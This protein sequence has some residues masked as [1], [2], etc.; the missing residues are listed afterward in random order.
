MLA[1][2]LYTTEKVLSE[3]QLQPL[4]PQPR[5]RH[6]RRIEAGRD[7][8]G[9]MCTLLIS[10]NNTRLL[11]LDF[12]RGVHEVTK[13][14]PRLGA[15][16]APTD[17]TGQQSVEAA[18][19]Q[20][21]LQVAVDFHRYSR[22]QSI[23]VKEVDPIRDAVLDDHPL[24]VPPHQFGRRPC[25]LIGQ[26]DR[27]LLVTQVGDDHLT[28][29]TVVIGQRDPPIENP[30]SRVLARDPLQLDLSPCRLRHLV[31]LP[32]QP[33]GAP[34]QRDELNT[35]PVELVELGVGR[36]L[37]IENQF[38][39]VPPGTLLP[40][41]N[42]AE[43]LI[44]LLI[45][46][47]FAVGVAK[48]ARL[49]VL[50]QERQNALLSPT[51]LGHVMLLNQS[52]L[53]MEGD[54]VKIQV[55]GTTTRQT[56]P[57]HGVE[58]PA[59]QLGIAG[60]VDPATVLGQERPL[61][62]DVQ[63]SKERQPLV[64]DY[65]H[66]MAVTRRP[67]ELQCQQRAESGARWDHLRSREPRLTEHAI[68]GDRGEHRQE[69]EQAAEFSPERLRA[70]IQLPDVGD[71]RRGWP[72]SGW[73]LIVSSARQPRE[74]FVLENLCN[75][76]RTEGMSFV[77]QIAADV[78]DREILFAQ[79]DDAVAYGIGLGSGLGSF[80]RLEEEVASGVPAE[81]VDEDSEA[82]WGVTEAMSGLGAGETIDKEGTES[83]VL[84]VRGVSRLEEKGREVR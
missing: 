5:N 68:E 33:R 21:Q 27:R 66:D 61:G 14:M 67:E 30:R 46:T 60:R 55:E 28:H 42:E 7:E 58:P 6:V 69:K 72:R 25:Q 22:G 26:E 45:L 34:A 4:P 65:A 52:I 51:P 12:G 10:H 19:H 75:G 16:V 62:D 23:H 13:Q 43:D 77:G 1:I 73:A 36:Q 82:P 84:T 53:A 44:I 15:F 47:Q 41:P 74:P 37:G 49:G 9:V 79:G 24:G 20:S 48:D 18:G 29:R 39:R 64:Q 78:V 35:Q 56:E 31:D 17:A 50:R 81:L 76:D 32:H 63:A 80:S 2:W 11:H 40:E 70:Q 83:F 71:I 54:G 57:S 38:F 59:H 8:Q 3:H